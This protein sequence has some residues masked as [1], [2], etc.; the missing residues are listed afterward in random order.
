MLTLAIL[1][2]CDTCNERDIE[3]MFANRRNV[4]RRIAIHKC[5]L[6]GAVMLPERHDQIG[7]KARR[8]RRENTDPDVAIV[9]P[10]DSAHFGLRQPYLRYCLTPTLDELFA[11]LSQAHTARRPNKQCRTETRFQVADAAANRRLFD[12]QGG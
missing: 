11:R 6:H 2:P 1:P 9:A 8:E 7:Q 5:Q 3:L 4:F 10:S 12:S